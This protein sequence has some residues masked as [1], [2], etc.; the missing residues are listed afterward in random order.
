VTRSP[1]AAANS[2]GRQA[3]LVERYAANLSVDQLVLAGR[4]AEEVA[5]QLAPG[6]RTRYLGSVL[7]PSDEMALCLFEGT[8]EAVVRAAV[9]RASLAFERITFAVMVS[10]R[11][12]A[13]SGMPSDQRSPHRK[14]VAARVQHSGPDGR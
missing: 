8:S 10:R 1:A 2:I 4:R 5:S 13:S 6:A 12:G 9:E 7:L 11:S 14:S 3:F